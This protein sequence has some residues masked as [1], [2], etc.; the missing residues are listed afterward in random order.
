MSNDRAARYRRLALLETNPDTARVL[1][2]LADEA[3]KGVLHPPSHKALAIETCTQA[4]PLAPPTGQSPP[5]P[6][7]WGR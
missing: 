2:L 1:R 7:Y 5:T 4:T 6:R 3:E